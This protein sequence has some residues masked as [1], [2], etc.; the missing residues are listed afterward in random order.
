MITRAFRFM[1][2]I[3]EDEGLTAEQ[4]SEALVIMNDMMNGWPAEG[5][6]YVHSD[7]TL[8][9]TVNVPDEL[10]ESTWLTLADVLADEYGKVFTDKQQRRIDRAR[11]N[12]QSYYFEVPPAQLDEGLRPNW[13]P[14]Y[15]DIS[16]G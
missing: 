8:D 10:V 2:F 9:T 15:F 13:P 7:L 16:R 6:P 4:V 12:L 11:S 1:G 14:G 3:S 5:I